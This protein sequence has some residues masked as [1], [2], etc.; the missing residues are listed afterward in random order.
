MNNQYSPNPLAGLGSTSNFVSG[1]CLGTLMLL[2]Y[3]LTPI[4]VGH[5][6]NI[7]AGFDQGST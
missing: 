4:N 5:E 1:G 6:V 7:G 2:P 3:T